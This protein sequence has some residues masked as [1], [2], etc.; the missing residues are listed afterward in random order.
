M[1]TEEREVRQR[2]SLLEQSLRKGDPAR[3]RT[4]L[5]SQHP[6]DIKECMQQLSLELWPGLLEAIPEWEK[7]AEVV[8]QL[9]EAQWQQLMARLAPGDIARLIKHMES[10]DAADLV[11]CLSDEQKHRVLPA[12]SRE[13]RA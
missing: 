3:V 12:L 11:G 1:L 6:A 10:D 2:A 7:R 9:E 4:L 8:C 13:D 5:Q